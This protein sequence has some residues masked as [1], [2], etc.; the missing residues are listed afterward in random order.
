MLL[1]MPTTST[2]VIRTRH[3]STGLGKTD[4]TDFLSPRRLITDL[5]TLQKF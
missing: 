3:T 2:A 1:L 4:E 5:E